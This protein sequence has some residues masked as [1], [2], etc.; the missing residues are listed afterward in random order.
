MNKH[1]SKNVILLFTI[2]WVNEPNTKCDSE[3][4]TNPIQTTSHKPL[5]M[6]PI[7]LA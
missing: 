6:Q 2:S 7:A 4:N 3:I 5:F 1:K